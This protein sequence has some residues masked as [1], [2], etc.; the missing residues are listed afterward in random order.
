MFGGYRTLGSLVLVSALAIPVGV[1]GLAQEEEHHDQYDNRDQD[2]DNHHD[3][4]NDHVK[5]FYDTQHREYHEWN[6]GEDTAYR[7]WLETKHRKYEDFA[8]LSAEQQQAY[9]NWRREHPDAR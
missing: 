4:D 1:Y 7:H 5:R 2:R 9:W 6:V 8:R 3:A